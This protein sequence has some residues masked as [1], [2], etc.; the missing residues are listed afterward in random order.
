MPSSSLLT[1]QWLKPTEGNRYDSLGNAAC[2]GQCKSKDALNHSQAKHS[3]WQLHR[4]GEQSPLPGTEQEA[5][6]CG[7]R[8]H[9]DRKPVMTTF[10]RFEFALFMF[11]L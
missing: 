1:S 2:R 5:C 11:M 7:N 4:V 9:V 6:Q 3:K 8:E 10:L